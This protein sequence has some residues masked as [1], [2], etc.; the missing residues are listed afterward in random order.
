[1]VENRD[2]SQNLSRSFH[3]P[4]SVVEDSHYKPSAVLALFLFF[5]PSTIGFEGE[6]KLSESVFVNPKTNDPAEA[7]DLQLQ[8]KYLVLNNELFCLSRCRRTKRQSSN[9]GYTDHY[10]QPLMIK[11]AP[12]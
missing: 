3:R 1:M 4:E 6:G 10:K 11:T 12:K 7:Q 9:L 2:G 5:S 8:F